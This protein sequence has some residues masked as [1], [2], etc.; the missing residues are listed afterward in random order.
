MNDDEFDQML[1]ER[2]ESFVTELAVHAPPLPHRAPRVG[3]LQMSLAAVRARLAVSRIVEIL[4]WAPKLQ[5]TLALVAALVSCVAVVV[6]LLSV[7]P[8]DGGTA[9][10]LAQS[11]TTQV[12]VPTPKVERTP[13]AITIPPPGRGST[14]PNVVLVPPSTDSETEQRTIEFLPNSVRLMPGSDD[15][16][17]SIAERI[18]GYPNVEIILIGRAASIGSADSA[19]R[20]SET[21]VIT[22]RDKLVGFGLNARSIKVEGVGYDDPL[23]PDRDQHGNLIPEAAQRNRSVEIIVTPR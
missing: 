12:A 16:L 6:A 13:R 18:R 3:W 21:R 5:K 20:L 14:P 7:P 19:R 22:V 2:H 4:Q 11:A 17:R 1:R 9:A 8:G 10:G 15:I 23:V